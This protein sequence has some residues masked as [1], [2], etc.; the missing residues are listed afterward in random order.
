MKFITDYATLLIKRVDW[1]KNPN[2]A[3]A[4]K[5][6]CG[7]KLAVMGSDGHVELIGDFIEDKGCYYS[8][9]TYLA[10]KYPK[11][12]FKPYSLYSDDYENWELYYD[13]KSRKYDFDETYC[14]LSMEGDDCYCTMCKRC[15][16]CKLL[17]EYNDDFDILEESKTVSNS[18]DSLN[19]IRKFA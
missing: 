12:T 16:N 19:I 7:S 14:P 3:N 6:L 18:A 5:V 17:K 8:N 15:K 4:L 2:I 9:S 11:W 1:W 10:S 13:K